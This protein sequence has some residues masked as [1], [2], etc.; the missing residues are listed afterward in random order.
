MNEYEAFDRFMPHDRAFWDLGG[1]HGELAIHARPRVRQ[2]V[3]LE[4][5]PIAF[6]VLKRNIDAHPQKQISGVQAAAFNALGHCYLG[7]DGHLGDGTSRFNC[8]KNLFWAE[9]HTFASLEKWHKVVE[10]GYVRIDIEGA[11]EYVLTQFDWFKERLPV[12][13]LSLH[14]WYWFSPATALET[15]RTVGRLYRAVLGEYFVNV[16]INGPLVSNELI[17]VP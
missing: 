6:Q 8:G 1:Y 5:D 15:V 10:V 7:N 14:P 12:I 13:H 17:F 11:E 2:C 16:D 3:V 4:P 9:A